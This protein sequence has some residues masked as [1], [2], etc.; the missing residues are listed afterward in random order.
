MSG[1]GAPFDRLSSVTATTPT[2]DSHRDAL[3]NQF[4]LAD[5]IVDEAAIANSVARF[6]ER[7]ISLPTFAQLADPS[8]FSHAERVGDIISKD[9]LRL[10]DVKRRKG[11]QFS[12]EGRKE[13]MTFHGRARTNIRL[14]LNVLISE[15]LESATQLAGEKETMRQMERRSHD[16]H[17]RRLGTG[18]AQS[19]ATSDIHIEAIQGIKEINSRFISF[20]YPILSRYGVLMES[21]VAKG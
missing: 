15:D 9:L 8:T 17:I 7:G 11:L 5:R 14:A 18:N 10:C 21:R 4:G 3:E 12:E 2:S 1:S 19:I 20:A 6:R 13:L 16:S